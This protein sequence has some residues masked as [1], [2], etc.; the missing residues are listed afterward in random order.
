VK[1]R[2]AILVLVVVVAAVF[3]FLRHQNGAKQ[4]PQT[5]VTNVP[6]AENRAPASGQTNHAKPGIGASTS[7]GKENV[8]IQY[9]QGLIGKDQAVQATI[10]AENTK[11][12]DLYGK[13]VDQNGNPVSG[14]NVRG[15]IGLNVSLTAS[16]GEFHY[17]ET[18]SQGL[19]SFLG[20][21]GAGIGIWPQKEGYYYNL[22]IPWRRPDDYF[23]NAN[24]PI[25]FTM[26]KLN[27]V[28]PLINSAIDAKI[29]PEGNV[30]VFEIATGNQSPLGDFKVTLSRD[31]L[32]VNKSR[33]QFN[34]YAK[35]E[36]VGGGIIA[37]ADSYPYWAPDNG[38]QMFFEFSTSTN[39]VDWRPYLD[40]TFY[41]KNQQGQYGKMELHINS[42]VTPVRFKA[43]FAINPSGSQNLEPDLSKQN[44]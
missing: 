3:W 35:V 2:N 5:V 38:Y 6:A 29:I 36:I 21:H 20:I 30:T 22:K 43:N 11:S 44:L 4:S 25:V 13:V 32:T 42:S 14:A 34:W 26:W 40:K 15:S 12:L 16:G 1:S 7:L 28:A 33:D 27:G 31:P 9:Q 37:E 19:F 39:D 23:P 41:I 18:D 17:T 10:Q 24:S 8:A